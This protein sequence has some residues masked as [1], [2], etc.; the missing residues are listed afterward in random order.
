MVFDIL[1]DIL[2]EKYD[3][4]RNE[5]KPDTK[6]LDLGIDSIDVVEMMVE[7]EDKTGKDIELEERVETIG[8]LADY[9]EARI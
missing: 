9:I 2:V 5:I 8:D 3:C 7:V 1:A 4:D 6:F